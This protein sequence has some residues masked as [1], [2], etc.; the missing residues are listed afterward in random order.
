MEIRIQAIRFDATEKLNEFARKKVEK[1]QKTFEDIMLVEL[2]MKVVK[3]ASALNKEVG[4]TV[5]VPGDKLY[6][7]KSCDTFEESIDLCVDAMKGQLMK[8]KEKLR[9]R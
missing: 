5:N 8:F 2:Q 3:P 9:G 1:L 6:V 7:E 4:L